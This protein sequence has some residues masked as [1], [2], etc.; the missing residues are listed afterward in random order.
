M[1]GAVSKPAVALNSTSSVA[2][3][4]QKS[5]PDKP[6]A[7]GPSEPPQSPITSQQALASSIQAPEST[8]LHEQQYS[9]SNELFNVSDL[10][11]L[12]GREAAEMGEP[13]WA[14]DFAKAMAAVDCTDVLAEEAPFKSSLVQVCAMRLE[15]GLTRT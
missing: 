13:S 5:T 7:E 1:R 2:Q 6:H 15:Q 9:T 11:A 4:L 8:S 3:P 14:A 12:Y 10:Q